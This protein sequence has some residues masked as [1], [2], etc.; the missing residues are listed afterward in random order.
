[1][2]QE[3]KSLLPKINS[4]SHNPDDNHPYSDIIGNAYGF[5][6]LLIGALDEGISAE[7]LLRGLEEDEN[8]KS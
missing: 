3:D 7:E 6:G 8:L 4:L 2:S 1:M 5:Y